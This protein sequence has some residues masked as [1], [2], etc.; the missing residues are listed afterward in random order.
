MDGGKV[1]E[2]EG[3]MLCGDCIAR[4]EGNMEP[5]LCGAR[6]SFPALCGGGKDDGC[7]KGIDINEGTFQTCE[8]C[9][10]CARSKGI[11]EQ[12]GFD[13]S[14]TPSPFFSSLI[15]PQ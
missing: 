1:T 12:C 10:E 4:A 15:P 11:C 7:G 9:S 2:H 6:P 14:A 5:Y 8:Y 13:P 3:K